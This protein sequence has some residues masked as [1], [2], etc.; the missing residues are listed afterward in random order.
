MR[1]F[2]NFDWSTLAETCRAKAEGYKAMVASLVGEDYLAP[3]DSL[4]ILG[5]VSPSY[6]PVTN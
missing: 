2:T 5:V 1:R 3:E 4:Q 6:D